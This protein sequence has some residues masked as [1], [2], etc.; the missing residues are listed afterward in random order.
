MCLLLLLGGCTTA[1]RG[2]GADVATTGIGL[3]A[4]YSEANPIG[5]SLA[6]IVGL[7]ALKVA[8][9][10][11]A[12]HK[13][14]ADCYSASMGLA[15]SGYG[16]AAHNII[17]IAGGSSGVGIP[18]GLLAGWI[19]AHQVAYEDCYGPYIPVYVQ[20]YRGLDLANAPP[21][22]VRQYRRE[23]ENRGRVLWWVEMSEASVAM[24]E[25]D[26]VAGWWIV[27]RIE[28]E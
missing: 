6:G 26:A 23:A 3:A 16:A 7:F 11:V 17:V 27:K 14:P 10:Y 24:I 28:V 19:A 4:G 12:E 9:V 20:S 18:I 13:P 1:Q 8:S 22:S 25:R 15:F 21:G 2:Q 5:G